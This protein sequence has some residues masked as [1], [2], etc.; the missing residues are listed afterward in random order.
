MTQLFTMLFGDVQFTT[1]K[2]IMSVNTVGGSQ[3][4]SFLRNLLCT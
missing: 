4:A 3:Q 1:L 2:T